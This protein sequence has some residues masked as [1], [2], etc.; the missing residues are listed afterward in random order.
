MK[1]YKTFLTE[2]DTSGATNVEMAIVYGYNRNVKKMK[3][4][5][6][7]SAGGIEEDKFAKLKPSE[8]KTGKMVAKELGDV[9]SN[10]VHAGSSSA[11]TQYK[12]GKDT[13]SKSDLY[14]D[15]KNRFSLKKAGDTGTGAQLM[16]AKSGE[17]VGVVNYA[18]KHLSNNSP[19]IELE[20]VGE[21]ML[22][23]CM[24]C[25][26]HHGHDCSSATQAV[27]QRLTSPASRWRGR[28]ADR[29]RSTRTPQRTRRRPKGLVAAGA[30][31][32][33]RT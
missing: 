22:L 30:P 5:K 32:T 26:C 18:M 9:G 13:T 25:C 21:A 15:S 29:P 16:S 6:A 3:H 2:A 4:D 31:C 20:G 33:G 10:M 14:G 12:F 19:D 28:K 11:A 1:T 7:L 24:Q 27:R 8:I 23:L 17:A